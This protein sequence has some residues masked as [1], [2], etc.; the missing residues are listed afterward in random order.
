MSLSVLKPIF[1]EKF[2]AL[3]VL[4][5]AWSKSVRMRKNGVVNNSAGRFVDFHELGCWR[6]VINGGAFKFFRQK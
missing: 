2:S 4:D 6:C 1:E 5:E 3:D